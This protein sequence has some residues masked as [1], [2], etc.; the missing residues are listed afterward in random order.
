IGDCWP[1]RAGLRVRVARGGTG[2]QKVEPPRAGGR[3]LG[4]RVGRRSRGLRAGRGGLLAVGAGLAT[5]PGPHEG[6]EGPRE[7]QSNGG[8]AAHGGSSEALPRFTTTP[9]I[10]TP[11][12]ATQS[13]PRQWAAIRGQTSEVRTDERVGSSL[14]SDLCPLLTARYSLP[15]AHCCP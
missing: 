13:D 12:A 1:H 6:N 10:P 5:A 2:P 3:G 8:R 14:T 9:S 7:G 15:T 11:L 4:R